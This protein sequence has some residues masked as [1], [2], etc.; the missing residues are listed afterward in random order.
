MGA[1]G[2]SGWATKKRTFFL[3]LPLLN[4]Y[5]LNVCFPKFEC[6]IASVDLIQIVTLNGSL[7]SIS[8]LELGY[9]D[10]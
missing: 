1:K 5:N 6:E 10:K 8:S 7:A 9:K 3:Q 2:L 4:Q